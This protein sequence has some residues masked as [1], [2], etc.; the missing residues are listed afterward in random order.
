[1]EIQ[2]VTQLE[3]TFEGPDVSS[4]ADLESLQEQKVKAKAELPGL[5]SARFKAF[6]EISV[7]VILANC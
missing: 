2:K 6:K 7:Q 3:S 4:P 1:M 5:F